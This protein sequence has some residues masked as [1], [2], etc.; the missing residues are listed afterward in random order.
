MAPRM[1]HKRLRRV[2]LVTAVA[3]LGTC[4]TLA[5]FDRA[6]QNQEART[7][8][9]FSHQ[10]AIHHTLVREVVLGFESALFNLRNVFLSSN[11]VTSAEFALSAREILTRYP[12]ISAL[13]WVPI[14]KGSDRAALEAKVSQRIGREFFFVTSERTRAPTAEEYLPI[15][16]VEPLQ[17]N[18]Q[19]LGFD[20]LHGPTS[21]HL[22]RARQTGQMTVSNPVRLIQ[23]RQ[24]NQYGVTF[25][26]PVFAARESHQPFG[27]VQAVIRLADMLAQPQLGSTFTSL[28]LVYLDPD[29]EPDQRVLYSTEA[30]WAQALSTDV[31]A[32]RRGAHLEKHI[33][34]GDRQW[35][36]LYRPNAAWLAAKRDFTP[37][38]LL[39]GGLL[40]TGLL[41]SL[42]HILGRR[43]EVIGDEVERQTLE[44]TESRRQ[45]ESLMQSLPG[46]VFRFGLEG[47][48]RLLFMSNG[49][50]TLFG[51]AVAELSAGRPHPR[52]LIHPADLPMVRSKTQAALHAKQPFEI[53]YRTRTRSGET[54]WVLS[55]GQGVH[56]ADGH[57]RFIEGLVIDISARK[58]AE[59]E[60]LLFERR[61]QETQKRESLGLLAGGVAH[62]F[63]NLLTTI[64]G[65]A[66]L[67][68][69]ELP[70]DS[71]LTDNLT[72]IERAARHAALLCRQMLA[73]AGKGQ[74]TKKQLDLSLVIKNLLPLLH[75]S[76]GTAVDLVFHPAA[77]LPQINADAAEISQILMNL[78]IN[79]SEAM[80]ET[81]GRIIVSTYLSVVD[82]RHASQCLISNELPNGR[83]VALEVNDNGSGIEAAALERIFEPFFSTKFEGRGLGL[84]AVIG[85]VRGHK[86]AIQVK[87]TLGAGTVF[88]VFFP[89]HLDAASAA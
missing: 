48:H 60:Q 79:A 70:A 55:R 53:E 26:W 2:I 42:V 80:P 85:I 78:V 12:G 51:Y 28:D 1:T 6:R 14:V 88:T 39:A 16:F 83:Y 43:T 58:R 45:L 82:S 50:E 22:L 23:E 41:A 75:S 54:K 10:A 19:A 84:A 34:V 66:S 69:L 33:S 59:Q 31:Q 29:A 62:D 67:A 17:G 21:R 49:A 44:L 5:S 40:L 35:Q 68:K 38:R 47:H 20:L 25:I 77:D 89:L 32:F 46:M 8:A 65:N 64:L 76:V 4:L 72:Q 63:N 15:L 56:T 3:V 57:L 81:G 37:Y 52:E 73:Y 11:R 24:P 27:F 71:P 9:E 36:V 86:A 13:E 74:L 87:S 18:E 30:R 7:Q 61:M